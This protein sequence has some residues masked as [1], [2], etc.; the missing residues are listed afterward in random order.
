MGLFAKPT[1]TYVEVI[2][3]LA[4]AQEYT[5]VL[6]AELRDL[7]QPGHRVIVQ[8]GKSKYYSAIVRRVHEKKPPFDVKPIETL[9]DEE[10]IVTPLQLEFWS[11][12]ASYYCCTT[13]EV[14]QAA[15][16][17]GLK[18]SSET[19]IVFNEAYEG[20]FESL[21]EDEF[22]LTGAL[23]NRGEMYLPQVQELLGRKNVYPL[24]RRIF[25]LGIAVSAEEVADTYKPKTEIYIR[26]AAGRSSSDLEEAF[27]QLKRAPKQAELLLAFIQM[28]R[29][30]N[31]VSRSELLRE[32]KTDTQVL[33]KVVEKGIL[34]EFR[35]VVS[36]L[37]RFY[38][39]PAAMPQ[40][41]DAQRK[42]WDEIQKA[43]ETH[44]TVLLHGV[45]GSGKTR[46]YMEQISQ[47]LEEGKQVLFLLPEIA[48]TAQIINRLRSVFGDQVGIYHSRF[49]KNERVEI[50]HKVM[51]GDYRIVVGARSA[52][53]LPFKELGLCIIDEE[54]DPS[55][56]QQDPA[57]RYNARDACLMLAH[58]TT[59]KCILGSA[60][61]Q[62]ESFYNALRGKFKL[63]S[64]TERHGSIPLPR[65]EV[66]NL[67]KFR[68]QGSMQGLL[69]PPLLTAIEAA[70]ERREQVILFHN[71]R[72]FARYQSCETCNEVY[73]CPHCEVS[74]TYH[75]RSDQLIC[76]YCNYKEKRQQLCKR[77]GSPTLEIAGSGTEQLEENIKTCLPEARIGRMDLDT[78]RGKHAMGN[79]ISE[80]ENREIDILSG[81]QMLSKGL[82]FDHVSLVGVVLADQLLYYPGFRSAERAFQVLTQVS[83]RA[84]RKEKQGRALIQT[85]DP[86]NPVIKQVIAQNYAGL[87]R[88]EI[89][90]REKFLYPP[91]ARLIE[92]IVKS[93]DERLAEKAAAGLVALL[94]PQLSGIILGPSEPVI[95]RIR[96]QYLREVLLKFQ[97]HQTL[98]A[99]KKIVTD[100]I[101]SMKADKMWRKVDFVTNVDP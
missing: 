34:E 83:G 80:F 99:Q 51:S 90:L 17:A 69:S 42:A 94:I 22:L 33:A 35:S 58:M 4:L 70:L 40:L 30:Q 77:C 55:L 38:E 86:D 48:L 32:A 81:T 87:Y 89:S 66:V 26:I 15:L 44:R 46:L 50:W 37:G 84:G 49:N 3:P 57:P 100:C 7:V 20:D 93:F 5:Y 8:F 92:I 79:L 95:S 2:L 78:M 67:K 64:L 45:T 31:Y 18:I 13:G 29:N 91:F 9:A 12:M 27:E 10:P 98:P 56:K 61:P 25:G 41:N 88:E 11:W 60:T 82:D 47:T 43:F 73:F 23:R 71:R 54:H 59:A 76:H 97:D 52:L 72:G 28:I 19:K 24:L 53:F 14:M 16:P 96:N 39:E 6:P 74:L 1:Y 36:R 63:V 85:F 68:K 101:N 21:S 62:V 65:M 75:K